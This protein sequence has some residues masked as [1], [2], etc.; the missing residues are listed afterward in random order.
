MCRR[1]STT[2]EIDIDK[3]D[4]VV[5]NDDEVGVALMGCGAIGARLVSQLNT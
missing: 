2:A 5:C 3:M 1:S 4:A